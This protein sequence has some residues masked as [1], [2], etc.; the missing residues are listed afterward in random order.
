MPNSMATRFLLPLNFAIAWRIICSSTC[1]TALLTRVCSCG[2]VPSGTGAL[3]ADPEAGDSASACSSSRVPKS[4]GS[5]TSESL[6]IA[7]RST[8]WIS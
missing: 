5:I 3:S 1:S 7:A 4:A 6:K 2:A 8:V